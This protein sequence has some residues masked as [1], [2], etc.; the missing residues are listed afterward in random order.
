V[1]ET[2]EDGEWSV[3]DWERLAAA[4]SLH[5]ASRLFNEVRALGNKPYTKMLHS[6]VSALRLHIY[7]YPAPTD[8]RSG[9]KSSSNTLMMRLAALPSQQRGDG[10]NFSPRRN[11][12]L[13]SLSIL[14]GYDPTKTFVAYSRVTGLSVLSRRVIHGT[15]R[16]VVSSWTPP[17][18]VRKP[19]QWTSDAENQVAER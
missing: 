12:P 4:K 13:N 9:K 16:M 3:T 11:T 2:A 5:A 18:S 7:S 19:L 1:T 8:D 15:P 17:E 10:F 14:S 6:S